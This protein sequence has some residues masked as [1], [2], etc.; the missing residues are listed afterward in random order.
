MTRNHIISA[1]FLLSIVYGSTAFAQNKPGASLGIR[2][3]VGPITIDGNLDEAS[4]QTAD[5]AKDFYLNFPVDTTFAPFQTEVKVT[6][7]DQNLYFAFICLDDNKPFIVQSLRRD[8]DFDNN[9]NVTVLMGPY[10]DKINGFFFTITP[11]NVQMEGTINSGGTDNNSY[12]ATWDNKW[13]SKTTRLGDRWIA[14]ISIPFK[15]IRYKSGEENWNI[16]FL[17]WDRKHNLVSTWIAT[18]IQYT[19]GSFG[20]SGNLHWLD[21]APESTANISLIPY[22]AGI[23]ST[24]REANPVERNNDL[25][26]GLDAKIGV[27]PSL[28]LD[29]TVNPDFSQVEV[30]QQVINLTRFEFQFPERRQFFL[31]NNDIFDKGG[32]PESRPFFSRRIGL[33]KDS[34]GN[35]Q[36]VPI[37]YGARLSGSLSKKWRV[38]A[39]NMHTQKKLSL[40][41]P[42]QN[43]T[44]AALQ[45]NFW[46]QSNITLMYVDKASLNVNESDSLRYF[47]E[48]LWKY[49]VLRAGV[50]SLKVINDRNR[51]MSVDIELMSADNSRYG[52]IFYSQSYDPFNTEKRDAGGVFLNYNKRPGGIF[53]GFSFIQ[54]NYNAETGF[55]PSAEV[56][57]GQFNTFFSANKRFFPKKV[58]ARM[59]PGI[60]LN[61]TNI[62]GGLTTD[63]SIFASYG[64]TFLNT[65]ELYGG[66]NYIYQKLTNT[67][68]PIDE[69]LYT[70]FKS[71]EQYEWTAFR[72]GY[73]SDQR[74]VV[75]YFIEANRGGFYNGDNF[76]INGSFNVRFQP[77]GSF[78]LRFDY[79]DLRLADGYGKEKLVLVRPRFDFTFTDKLFFTAQAQYNNLADNVNLNAR[80][81]WRYKPA[82][83]FFIVYTEN[84]F[85]D[86]FASKNRA[87]VFKF[88]YW[89]NI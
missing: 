54:K 66:V 6:F 80:F 48:S 32:F 63:K 3:A 21:K 14:E 26:A 57:P 15:S 50:D 13:Y 87:L 82:S 83:D 71:G 58:V 10:N 33:A 29:L 4:W 7:D 85:S 27:T 25:Q 77:Y 16:N 69:E 75:R 56:Y 86:N 43:Y 12:S 59:G 31:E 84:Y 18:P 64:L 38:S 81:Q 30:D 40:G 89:L 61:F 53:T 17:R 45:R 49:K 41:L 19:A 11:Y 39:L 1:V 70:T 8:F 34:T 24:D 37:A 79:N 9:D 65:A 36:Q 51:V 67:F 46:K 2:K 22:V 74:K 5:V 62:P 20:Y 72:V 47:Q 55:V 23:A 44:V 76:N 60:D 52:S 68:N 73:N 35:L 28:N 88:T 42:A 78:S